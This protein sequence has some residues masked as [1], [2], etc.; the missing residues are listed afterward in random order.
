MI[1]TFVDN[2]V[3]ISFITL[4][5]PAVLAFGKWYKDTKKIAVIIEIY[6]EY[7]KNKN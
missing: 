7:P 4:Y 6:H 2:L 5:I 1:S 3:T